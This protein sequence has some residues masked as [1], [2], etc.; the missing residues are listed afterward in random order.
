MNQLDEIACSALSNRHITDIKMIEDLVKGLKVKLYADRGYISQDLKIRL[1]DQGTD[2]M[3][4][5]RKNMRTVQLC[6][7]DEYHLK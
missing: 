4:Y 1:K 2:L 6:A 5:H 7:Q 3:T